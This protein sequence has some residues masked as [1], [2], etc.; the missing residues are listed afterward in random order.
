MSTQRDVEERIAEA[1]RV[2]RELKDARE[3]ERQRMQ[4]AEIERLEEHLDEARIRLSDVRSA[5]DAAWG[6]LRERIE[7][8]IAEL[9]RLL[10][11]AKRRG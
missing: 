4:H 2:L 10:E 7:R 3:E 9:R 5:A 11:E 1:E 6:E 8:V